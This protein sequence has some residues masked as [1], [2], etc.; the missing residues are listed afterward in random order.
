MLYMMFYGVSLKPFGFKQIIAIQ[1]DFMIQTPQI[2]V[3]EIIH[4]CSF[5]FYCEQTG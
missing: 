5:T 3:N 2:H 1:R 4:S